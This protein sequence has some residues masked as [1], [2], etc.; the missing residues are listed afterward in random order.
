[1]DELD[2]VQGCPNFLPGEPHAVRWIS[3]GAGCLTL[4]W[5]SGPQHAPQE[6]KRRGWVATK[7]ITHRYTTTY[8]YNVYGRNTAP[9]FSLLW[10]VPWAGVSCKSEYIFL[11]HPAPCWPDSLPK[12]KS[13]CG[14][15]KILSRAGFGPRAGLWTC[16]HWTILSGIF[17]MQYTSSFLEKDLR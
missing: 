3:V 14:P 12:F 2:L 11:R 13:S 5:D 10:S 15:D 9:S 17:Y 16:L 1:M 7:D 8:I 6:R 4:T